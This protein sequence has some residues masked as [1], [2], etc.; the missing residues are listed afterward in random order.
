MKEVTEGF[1]ALKSNGQR[2]KPADSGYA[3]VNGIKVYY[4]VYGEG[5]PV[6]LLHGAYM[7]IDM[8]WGRLIPELS[9]TRKIIGIE[10]QGHGH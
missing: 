4:E 2:S 7:T 6:V 9:K 5:R 1:N 8:N 10:L 3:P